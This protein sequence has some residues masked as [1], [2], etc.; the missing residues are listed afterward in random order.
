[1]VDF[2][3]PLL[4]GTGPLLTVNM[5]RCNW[6]LWQPA[7]PPLP[8]LQSFLPVLSSKSL[9]TDSLDAREPGGP[10]GMQ[11]GWAWPGWVVG[12]WGKDGQ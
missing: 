5:E 11:G 4:P 7:F 9:Q 10:G 6:F 2:T 12:G 3:L 1:M 8:L